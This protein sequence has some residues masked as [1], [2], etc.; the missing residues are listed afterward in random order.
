MVL[1]IVVAIALLGGIASTAYADSGS[2]TTAP[3]AVTAADGSAQDDPSDPG[4]P[5]D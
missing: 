2:Q 4:L 3:T 5:P 1:V